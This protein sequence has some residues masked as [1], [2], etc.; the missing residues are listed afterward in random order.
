M[1][2]YERKL[3]TFYGPHFWETVPRL[4]IPVAEAKF[5]AMKYV[6]NLCEKESLDMWLEVDDM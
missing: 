6:Q 1:T 3:F 2:Y 4:G 5:E